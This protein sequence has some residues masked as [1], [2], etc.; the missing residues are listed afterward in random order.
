M[1]TLSPEVAA[2]LAEQLKAM[3]QGFAAQAHTQEEPEQPDTTT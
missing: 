1:S 2:Q 3:A